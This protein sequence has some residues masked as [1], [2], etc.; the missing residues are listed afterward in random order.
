MLVR[1]EDIGWVTP[2][3]DP[4]AIAQIISFAASAAANTN[5][6]GHRAA[7]V[8][9]RFTRQIA[10]NAYRDLMDRLLGQQISR[11]RKSLKSAA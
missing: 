1:E 3:E 5:E 11:N 4:E 9:P 8:A 7:I 10:L 6:K 2:P